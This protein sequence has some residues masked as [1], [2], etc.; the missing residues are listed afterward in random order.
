MNDAIIK[1]MMDVIKDESGIFW[2][3]DDARLLGYIKQS[4]DW[5]KKFHDF[6]EIEIEP[7]TTAF[8]LITQRVRYLYN[9]RV[10]DFELNYE[11]TINE[12]SVRVAIEHDQAG[13]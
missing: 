11:Y 9:N 3:E 10:D 6:R 1:Q 8:E 13:V 2:Q 5:I 7:Y 12:Y 4:Y